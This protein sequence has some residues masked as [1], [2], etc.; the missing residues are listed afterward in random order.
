MRADMF[1]LNSKDSH[2]SM[3]TTHALLTTTSYRLIDLS[4]GKVLSSAKARLIARLHDVIDNAT[5]FRV[6]KKP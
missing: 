2:T 4:R 1:I 3:Y 5:T 6:F